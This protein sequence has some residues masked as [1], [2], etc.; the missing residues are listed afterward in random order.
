MI[1][2]IHKSKVNNSTIEMMKEIYDYY[3]EETSNHTDYRKFV[4]TG[5]DAKEGTYHIGPNNFYQQ[6]GEPKT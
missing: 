3:R 2:Y 5:A 6:E 4:I 1:I